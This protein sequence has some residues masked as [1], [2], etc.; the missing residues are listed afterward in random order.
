MNKKIFGFLLVFVIAFFSAIN[1]NINSQKKG[2]SDVSLANVEALAEE[3]GS[4]ARSCTLTWGFTIFG[5][6]AN[7]SCSVTCDTGFNAKCEAKKC[8]CVA[9]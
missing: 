6:G 8:E 4:G 7:H 3:T 1:V 9:I 2:L 5:I